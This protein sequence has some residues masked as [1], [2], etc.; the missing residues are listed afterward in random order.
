MDYATNT[1]QSPEN[2]GL[3]PRPHRSNQPDD[4]FYRD[5]DLNLFDGSF[6]RIRNITLGY[7]LPKSVLE[8]I[9][10]DNLRFYVSSNNPFTFTKYPGFD[11]ESSNHS[12]AADSRPNSVTPRPGRDLDSYPTTKNFILGINVNF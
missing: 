11:P 12:G 5:S 6:V 10:L 1:F 2:P 4:E 8:K 9:N 7:T 3:Y